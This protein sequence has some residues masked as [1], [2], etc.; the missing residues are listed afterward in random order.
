MS[1]LGPIVAG[2]FE[3]MHYF[4]KKLFHFDLGQSIKTAN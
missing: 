1:K 2:G 3:K 4:L